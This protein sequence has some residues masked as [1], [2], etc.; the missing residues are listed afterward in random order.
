LKWGGSSDLVGF[1]L[2]N[3][4]IVVREEIHELPEGEVVDV[5]VLKPF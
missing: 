1:M 2:A 3:A 5:V 4:L